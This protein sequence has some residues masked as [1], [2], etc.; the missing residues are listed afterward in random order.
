MNT[1]KIKI[2]TSE[3][4]PEASELMRELTKAL[5]EQ[6]SEHKISVEDTEVAVPKAKGCELCE[7]LLT[8]MVGIG[9]E[10]VISLLS[11]LANDLIEKLLPPRAAKNV[12]IEKTPNGLVINNNGNNNTYN[13]TVNIIDD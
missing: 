4:G 7:V 6:L 3:I 5:Q 11:R 1:M 10:V 2:H 13:I 12:S 8:I 9:T